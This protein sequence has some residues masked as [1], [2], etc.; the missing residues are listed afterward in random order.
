MQGEGEEYFINLQRVYK[1]GNSGARTTAQG[2]ILL[3]CNMVVEEG[4]VEG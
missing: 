4:E 2:K 3:L 1:T